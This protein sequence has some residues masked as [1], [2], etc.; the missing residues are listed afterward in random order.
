M[1]PPP[2]KSR[3]LIVLALASLV[4]LGVG[5]TVAERTHAASEA[6]PVGV[7]PPTPMGAM[8]GMAA[9]PTATPMAAMP[10]MEKET[11]SQSN[12]PPKAGKPAAA[13]PN[14]L[15]EVVLSPEQQVLANVAT[16]PVSRRALRRDLAMVGQVTYDESRQAMV[17]AR[18]EG[19]LDH[20]YVSTTG[21]RITRG[22]PMAEV[23]SPD[24]AA[25]VQE[26][27]ASLAAVRAASGASFGDLAAGSRTILDASR[28]RLRLWGLSQAQ[29]SGLERGSKPTVNLPLLAPRSGI[30]IKKMVEAGQYVHV[31]DPLYEIA[32]LSTVWVLADVFQ[33]RM[34]QVHVGQSVAVTTPTYVGKTFIGKVTFVYP[35]LTAETRTVKLRIALPN[36]AGLLKPDMYVTADLMDTASDAT[37]AIPATA[38]LDAGERKVVF[39]EVR[40]GVFRPREVMLGAKVG[41]DYPVTGGLKAGERVATSGGFLL[42]ANSQIQSGGSQG[43]AGMPGMEIKP[44][45]GR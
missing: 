2:P 22:Q 21:A 27:R 32:D 11:P 35:F 16:A 38:V 18:V 42:D 44:K 20:L 39:V 43:M 19:R 36:S 6:K 15:A 30:V 25:T 13:L 31:G 23:Y 1:T 40:S 10:G 34:A 33:G 28:Q 37:L 4:A 41:G 7:A 8:P 17:T 24:L 14:G 5:G 26:D 9:A 45:E 3:R 29:I 12:L